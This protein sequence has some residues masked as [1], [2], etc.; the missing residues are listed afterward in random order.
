[1]AGCPNPFGMMLSV[2]LSISPGVVTAWAGSIGTIPP[3]WFLCD[4]TNGTPDLRDKFLV[5]DGP[6]FSVGD[7]GGNVSHIH[8]YFSDVHT[9][10][11]PVTPANM[12][13]GVG[14]GLMLD[15]NGGSGT[16]DPSNNLPTYYALA[17]IMF[18]G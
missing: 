9:H 11:F 6:N 8:N 2:L 16:T 4:G 5:S 7:E 12:A 10:G 13:G 18:G 17:Y 3:G 1:M 15:P 14:R